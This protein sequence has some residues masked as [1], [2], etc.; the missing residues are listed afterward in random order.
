[1]VVRALLAG[2]ASG[3]GKLALHAASGRGQADVVSL[4]LKERAADDVDA[5]VRDKG[6]E[7]P[8]LL[9]ARGSH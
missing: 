2:H 5:R 4:L 1:M 7:T 8:L 6:R 9:A 3:D